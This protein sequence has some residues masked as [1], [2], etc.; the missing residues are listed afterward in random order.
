[1]ILEVNDRPIE[2]FSD[3]PPIVGSVRP[4]EKVRLKVSRWGKERSIDVTLDEREEAV[5]STDDEGASDR[6]PSNALGLTVEPLDDELRRRARDLEGGVVVSDIESDNAY[7]AGI[8]RGDVIQMINNRA[9]R[10]I[11]DFEEIVADIEPGR[12]VALLV[13]RNG[14]SQFLAYTPERD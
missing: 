9:I 8:R 5:A 12:S 4:G 13:W 3:L 7:R 11:D 14:N 1:M 10:S 2:V 6:Q